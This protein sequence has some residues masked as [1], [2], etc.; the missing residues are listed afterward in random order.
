[1]AKRGGEGVEANL[2]VYVSLR[3]RTLRRSWVD[4]TNL[5]TIQ[6]RINPG[7]IRGC[8]VGPRECTGLEKWS[9]EN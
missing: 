6:Q 9:S 7:Q 8:E 1:M 4:V 5:K 2:E 3:A